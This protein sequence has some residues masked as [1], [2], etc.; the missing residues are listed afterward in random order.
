MILDVQV[1]MIILKKILKNAE[2]DGFVMNGA[3]VKII[4]I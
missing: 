3:A 4:S 1:L 2:K